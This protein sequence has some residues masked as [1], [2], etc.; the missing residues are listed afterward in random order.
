MNFDKFE[1]AV[2][3]YKERVNLNYSLNVFDALY[4][5]FTLL[6]QQI[7]EIT[8]NDLTVVLQECGINLK[9]TVE[10]MNMM[11]SVMA[12]YSRHQMCTFGQSSVA[13]TFVC[14]ASVVDPV[15]YDEMCVIAGLDVKFMHDKDYMKYEDGRKTCVV[16]GYWLKDRIDEK[17]IQLLPT[18]QHLMDFGSY[19]VLCYTQGSNKNITDMECLLLC[20][21]I[22]NI[23]KAIVSIKDEYAHVID[24]DSVVKLVNYISMDMK[25][26]S[27]VRAHCMYI[28]KIFEVLSDAEKCIK[29]N[30]V[31][32]KIV[33]DYADFVF[34]WYLSMLTA[35]QKQELLSKFNTEVNYNPNWSDS[36]YKSHLMFS[37]SWLN[38]C[39]LEVD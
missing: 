25:I 36:V 19:G 1:S 23:L 16:F 6:V 12:A 24:Q 18:N 29:L 30:F 39:K 27:L 15:Y 26:P 3:C 35:E 37:A 10:E 8:N 20:I 4:D 17:F 11:R 9:E 31:S 21:S 7:E 32:S 14:L 28:D 33:S 13:D 34:S 5:T 38:S 22:Q 2:K